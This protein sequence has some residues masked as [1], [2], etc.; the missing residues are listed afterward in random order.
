[1]YNLTPITE[2]F[3]L[4]GIEIAIETSGTNTLQGKIDWYCF[5]PKKFKSPIE[6]AF[7]LADEMKIIINHPSDFNWAKELSTSLNP[8]CLRILQ[9]EWGKQERFL[10]EI[11]DFVKAN[12]EW[13]ISL[14][15]HKIMQIP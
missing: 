8:K 4:H 1:L 7:K 13:R 9:P 12:P 3:E 5:S 2:L 14:Q 10:P 6:E 15:T 11:I